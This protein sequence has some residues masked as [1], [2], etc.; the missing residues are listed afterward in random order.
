MILSFIGETYMT[1]E[2]QIFFWVVLSGLV[3]STAFLAWMIIQDKW[4]KYKPK[5]GGRDNLDS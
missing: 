3:F 2:E 4:R 5:K 1:T